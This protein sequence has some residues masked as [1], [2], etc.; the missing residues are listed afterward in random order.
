MGL[1]VD[2]LMRVVLCSDPI[3]VPEVVDFEI[4]YSVSAE[5]RT[6]SAD[7]CTELG[8]ATQTTIF[9]AGDCC[10]LVWPVRESKHWF[11]MRLWSQARY[12][13]CSTTLVEVP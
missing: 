7:K 12:D 13:S 4:N 11:Q 10:C 3:A 9:A 2:E 6:A 1:A 5:R 8:D